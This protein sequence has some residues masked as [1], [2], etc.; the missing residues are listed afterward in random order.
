MGELVGGLVVGLEAGAGGSPG[1][2]AGRGRRTP[3][4]RGRAVRVCE[5]GASQGVRGARLVERVRPRRPLEVVR[6][7][8]GGRSPG[9]GYRK[10]GTT[11]LMNSSS[12]ARFSAW[13]SPVSI[14]KLYSST[15]SSW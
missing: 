10:A 12:D 7:L 14:Q 13:E 9:C 6:P 1:S 4:R 8:P 5:G 2:A 15:P 3:G 11:S